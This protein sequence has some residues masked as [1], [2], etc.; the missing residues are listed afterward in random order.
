MAGLIVLTMFVVAY[1]LVAG[2]VERSAVT[3]PMV[4]VG[5]GALAGALS[6]PVDVATD[7][8]LPL[9]E[10]T[11]VLI[12]FSD[13]ARVD[14]TLLRKR[15]RMPMRLL[16]VGLPLTVAMGFVTG[17]LVLP[18]LGLA[19]ALLASVMLAPTDAA[20]GEAVV[21]NPAVPAHVRQAAKVESGLNDGLVVPMLA[22]ATVFASME[23]SGE[24][25]ADWLVAA[26]VEVGAGAAL[27]G[28]VGWIGAWAFRRASETAWTTPRFRKIGAAALALLAF[29]AADAVGA[30]GFLAAFVAG[31]V[32]GHLARDLCG[33]LLEFADTEGRLLALVSF[34]LFGV[35]ATP[36]AWQV[37][38]PRV[39]VYALLSLTVV[40]M[41]PVALALAGR[42]YRLITMGYLG[43]F[44]PRGI[45]SIVF[46]VAAREQLGDLA[47]VSQ[48]VT[49]TVVLSI[50][51][52]GLSAKPWSERYGRAM[53][54]LGAGAPEAAGGPE[55]WQPSR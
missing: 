35:V 3:P 8:L 48:A 30:S 51:L 10:V 13:A 29:L 17:L 12:L 4:F 38:S 36:V 32:F 46:L 24:G 22:A 6:T 14:L 55:V 33:E 5:A 18:S 41:I 39:V 45:A 52:H 23:E 16:L 28:T 21:E 7:A 26:A 44:G 54:G 2:R 31:G 42:S 47:V 49:L 43:W 19:G 34:F 50:V 9:L 11:L 15:F 40:R 27:G 1:A 20:L 25:V 53:A 37:V